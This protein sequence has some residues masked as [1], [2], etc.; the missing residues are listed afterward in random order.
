MLWR[1]PEQEILSICEELGIGFVPWAP[2]G[3][4][5]LTGAIDMGTS[6][7]PGDFRSGTS[8]MDPPNRSQNLAL[9]ELAKTWALRKQATPGQIALAWLLAQKPFI[10]PIPGT[11]QMPHMLENVGAAY[12]RF[13]PTELSEFNRS[14]AAVNVRG[15]RLPAM[16]QAWSGVEARAKG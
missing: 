5:F 14:V 9:V 4:G 1:G 6:F 16:V 3:F 15:T 12:I 13:T 2:L 8:R 10:V 7:A 11:T